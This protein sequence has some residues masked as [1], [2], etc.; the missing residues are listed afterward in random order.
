MKFLIFIDSEN[1]TFAITEVIVD[2]KWKFH[3]K[4]DNEFTLEG[5][6]FE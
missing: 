2:G 5:E 3:T 1:H 4:N 6:V